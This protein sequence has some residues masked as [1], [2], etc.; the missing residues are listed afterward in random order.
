MERKGRVPPD[1]GLAKAAT[2]DMVFTIDTR[3]MVLHEQL[4][5][6]TW[7]QHSRHRASTWRENCVN[8]LMHRK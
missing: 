8:A 3:N 5:L 7:Q 6:A 4:W 2:R 1:S